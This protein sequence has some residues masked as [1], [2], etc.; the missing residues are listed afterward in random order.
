ML[1]VDDYE[2]N[3]RIVSLFIEPLGWAWTMAENGAEAV[4]LCN[5]RKF[6]VIVMDMQMPVMD[7]LVATRTLRAGRGPNQSTPI[8]ALSANAMDHHRKAWS[9]IGVDD[10]LTKPVDPEALITTLAY[11]ASG[12]ASAISEVA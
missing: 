2:I 12:C 6:D 3:R 9:D 1:I 5:T 7:G 11:K 4:E 10:F 8:V